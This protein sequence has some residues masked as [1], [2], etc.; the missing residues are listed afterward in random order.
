MLTLQI[1]D[2]V[3]DLDA[4]NVASDMT[5]DDDSREIQEIANTV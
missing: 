3:A 4:R 5:T 2:F 1:T